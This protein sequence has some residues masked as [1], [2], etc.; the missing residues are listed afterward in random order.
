MR[1][2]VPASGRTAWCFREARSRLTSD[3]GSSRSPKC[4]QCVGQTDDAGGVLAL[5]DAVDAE[6]A[7]VDV[8]V[9]VHVAGVVRAGGDAGLAADALLRR[10]RGRS[11]RRR[12]RAMAPVGQQVTHGGVVAVVAALRADRERELREAP[13]GSCVD[14]VAVS[15]RRARRFSV[16][17]ATTQ[18]LQ[19]TQ[20]R[21][22]MTIPQPRMAQASLSSV[23]EVDAHAGAAHERVGLVRA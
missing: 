11:R 7:L 19:P 17:Q 15:A 13:R 20:R 12:A 23:D 18:A 9:G 22:S 3:C 1:G 8:A 5:L 4:M 16:L 6:G 14:P 10:R 2:F 21:V